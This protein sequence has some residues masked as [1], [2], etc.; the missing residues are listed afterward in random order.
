MDMVDEARIVLFV[1]SHT[2]I[3]YASGHEYVI[4]AVYF[5]IYSS[6]GHPWTLVSSIG[7]ANC[8]VLRKNSGRFYS[9][10]KFRICLTFSFLITD[11]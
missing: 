1:L 7:S 8:P 6:S 11:C 9:S 4:Y 5:F 3:F 10:R 2:S